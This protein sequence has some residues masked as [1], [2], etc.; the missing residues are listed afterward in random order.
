MVQ[1]RSVT[2]V[3]FYR[4]NYIDTTL[5]FYRECVSDVPHGRKMETRLSIVAV[6]RTMNSFMSPRSP[7]VLHL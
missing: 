3:T 1:L 7:W 4:I 6:T 2:T 5:E